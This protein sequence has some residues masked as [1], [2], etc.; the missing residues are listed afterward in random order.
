MSVEQKIDA[1]SAKLDALVATIAR[2]PAFAGALGG[3]A[4]GAAAEDD[5]SAHPSILAFDD[6]V[7]THLK[8]YLDA[9]NKIDGLQ[10]LG[11]LAQQGFDHLR[12][13]L[14]A[15]VKCKK[16]TMDALQKFCEPLL[17]VSK[18]ADKVSHLTSHPHLVC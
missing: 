18:A 11:A 12:K 15:T 16:P 14:L 13:V 10:S 5:G 2:M 8:G 17:A 7:A 1:L 3:A 6:L 9:C 4:G